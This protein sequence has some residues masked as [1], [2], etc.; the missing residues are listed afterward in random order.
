MRVVRGLGVTSLMR[1]M[2]MMTRERERE[3]D[4]EKDRERK[5]YREVCWVYLVGIGRTR[6]AVADRV[7][8][9]PAFASPNPFRFDSVLWRREGVVFGVL[10]GWFCETIQ[11]VNI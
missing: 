8:I 9:A 3:R 5:R 2:R 4:R 11:Y 1:V 6:R 10:L 7:T